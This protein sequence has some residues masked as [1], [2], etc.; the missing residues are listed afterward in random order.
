MYHV[1]FSTT[2]VKIINITFSLT[3]LVCDVCYV[4]I[5]F[6]KTADRFKGLCVRRYMYAFDVVANQKS[7]VQTSIYCPGFNT[8]A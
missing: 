5:Y 4:S 3:I 8:I 6:F 1:S 7:K 2:A